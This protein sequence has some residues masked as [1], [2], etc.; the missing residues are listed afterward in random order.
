MSKVKQAVLSTI[1]L[2]MTGATQAFAKV[3]V[4]PANCLA[5][6]HNI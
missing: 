3:L 5:R 4:N 6:M 2:N 1:I